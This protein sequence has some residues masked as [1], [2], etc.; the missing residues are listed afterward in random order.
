MALPEL[1]RHGRQGEYFN[2]RIFLVYMLDGVVQVSR[3]IEWGD[4]RILIC[5]A[6]SVIVFFIVVY[7]YDSTTSRT[8]GFAVFQYEWAV[9]C[10][11]A[12]LSRMDDVLIVGRRRWLLLRP[13]LRICSMGL[14][15]PRGPSGCGSR[16]FS[17]R[18]L[19]WSI[20]YVGILLVCPIADCL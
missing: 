7:A 15:P 11:L 14:I 1:Y 12:R 13:S 8:D 20:P 2:I 5:D 19:F 10:G 4:R 3:C 6:Q 9:V 17:D 16:S 18:P